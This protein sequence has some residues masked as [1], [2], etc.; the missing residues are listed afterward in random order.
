MSLIFI[1]TCVGDALC[2]CLDHSVDSYI[3]FARAVR[4]FRMLS[5]E[6]DAEIR[7][8]MRDILLLF[9]L[10]VSHPARLL[11]LDIGHPLTSRDGR[12]QSVRVQLVFPLL[13]TKLASRCLFSLFLGPLELLSSLRFMVRAYSKNYC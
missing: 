8:E 7:N 2:V 13:C 12:I 10:A 6:R 3:L 5:L 1:K 11:R 4:L 9:T